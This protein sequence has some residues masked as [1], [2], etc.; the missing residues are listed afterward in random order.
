MPAFRRYIPISPEQRAHL[1]ASLAQFNTL[2]P[3]L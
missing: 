2:L 3:S 1:M